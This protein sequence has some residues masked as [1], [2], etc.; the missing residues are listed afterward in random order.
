MLAVFMV[1]VAWSM[2]VYV[3]TGT[4]VAPVDAAF[5]SIAGFSTTASS[6]LDD[7][8]EVSRGV[9]AWRSL[10]QWLGGLGAI[11]ALVGLLPELG[12]GAPEPGHS[13]A[14]EQ[15]WRR[16]NRHLHRLLRRLAGVYAA[17]TVVGV[18]VLAGAGLGPYDALSVSLTTISTGGFAD[19]RGSI[20]HFDSAAVE[21]V[22]LGGMAVSGASLALL[23]R[24]LSGEISGFLRST[25]LRAYI[26][27]LSVAGGVAVVGTAPEA[28]LTHTSVR[29]ALFSVTSALST[30]GHTVT[31][32]TDWSI[33]LQTMLL[34]LM[35]IG[36]MSGSAGGGFSVLRAVTMWGIV[37][38]EIVR[39]LDRNR[40]VVVK[41]GHRPI[42]EPVISRMVGFQILSVLLVMT[43]AVALAATGVDLVGA[44]SG[45]VA[46]LSTVGPALGDLGP[47]RSISA[48]S[49][50]TQL[51]L[52]VLMT[53]GRLEIYPVARAVS[54]VGAAGARLIVRVRE[55]SS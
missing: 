24:G 43:G 14:T 16:S 38:R 34:V 13:R 53:A 1:A 52:M 42:G 3:I 48:Q 22:V 17:L 18:V 21:W 54:A 20:A 19:H 27:I 51:T 41:V 2:L 36:A 23:W 9:L 28:G 12:V 35:A 4:I 31:D 8:Q 15:P 47:G 29:Q 55:S 45:A 40:V 6:V 37:R 25:E 39:Q 49:L 10:T 30:T 7:P 44:G 5:E 33:G 46:S 11:V 50:G 32:W 26:M